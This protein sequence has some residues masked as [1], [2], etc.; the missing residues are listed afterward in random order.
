MR[1][2]TFILM[3]L[4]LVLV[5]GRIANFPIAVMVIG[6]RSMEP[7]LQIGDVII[8]VRDE[9]RV[10]DIVVYCLDSYNLNCVVHR[11]VGYDMHG[12]PIV[13]GDANPAPDPI[14]P[15]IEYVV[16]LVIP[17]E[18]ILVLVSAWIVYEVYRGSR[19]AI[20]DPVML[21]L[22][23]FVVYLAVIMSL[24]KLVTY[25]TTVYYPR[26]YIDGVSLTE[27][28]RSVTITVNSTL[29]LLS[30]KNCTVNTGNTSIPVEAVVV[31]NTI[32]AFLTSKVWTAIYN[33]S[34]VLAEAELS[35]K[36][37]SWYGLVVLDVPLRYQW[38]RLNLT[39]SGYDIAVEN[40]NPVL[41]TV[42]Y[43]VK[44]INGTRLA[45]I[46]NG[47]VTV[48]PVSK[49]S[50]PVGFTKCDKLNVIVKYEFLGE[51]IV[52]AKTVQG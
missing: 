7:T 17:R 36:L 35:C 6:G 26:L 22:A 11:L 51:V 23:L 20:R 42:N 5:F 41:F 43:T 19:L 10:G 21:A 14:H 4:L 39:V 28:Y 8:A 50:I 31:N 29:K 30:V 45:G 33:N 27:D 18:V 49:T 2:A 15:D 32:T 47:T 25:E 13:K 44:C 12:R 24:P 38:K 9:P 37:S 34:G 52:D 40:P 3:I 48:L 46:Q 1:D 16:K